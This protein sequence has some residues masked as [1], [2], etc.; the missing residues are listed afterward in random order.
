MDNTI[1]TTEQVRKAIYQDEDFDVEELQRLSKFASSSIEEKTGYDFGKDQ[2]K[3]PIAVQ[4][5]ILMVRMQYFGGD[6][7][8]K[9][10]N[11]SLGIQG[12]IVDLQV[13]AKRKI[14]AE[15]AEA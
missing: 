1:L 3:E 9:E 8:N 14:A 2:D 15:A 12:M 13:I 11:Y 7:Y 5:A 4:C 10:Y 6:G